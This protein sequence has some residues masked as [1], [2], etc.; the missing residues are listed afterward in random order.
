MEAGGKLLGP[1]PGQAKSVT[2]GDESVSVIICSFYEDGEECSIIAVSNGAGNVLESKSYLQKYVVP[3]IWFFGACVVLI[4]V[5]VNTCCSRWINS[6]ILPP[7]KEIRQGMKK[8]KSGVLD[9]EI[10]VLRQDEQ[11]EVCEEFNN[12]MRYRS[13]LSGRKKNR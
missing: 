4:V 3:Y 11:G 13:S 10:P 9:G 2:V 6:L 7:K 1:I 12:L 8:V 5:L